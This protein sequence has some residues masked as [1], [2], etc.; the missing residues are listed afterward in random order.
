MKKIS[1]LDEYQKIAMSTFYPLEDKSRQLEYAVLALCG[2]SGELANTLKKI[3]YYKDNSKTG[4]DMIEELSDVL[5]YVACVADA[6]NI[7]LSE[8]ATFNVNKILAKQNRAKKNGEIFEGAE[9]CDTEYKCKCPNK[10]CNNEII[11]YARED[12]KPEYHTTVAIKCNKCGC[13]VWFSLPVN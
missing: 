1:K 13:K 11:L 9:Y 3:V 2:E 10:D 6:I 8:L 4:K 7:K 12:Y 5:W